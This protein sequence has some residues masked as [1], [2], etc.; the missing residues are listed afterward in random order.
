MLLVQPTGQCESLKMMNEQRL[1]TLTLFL[2]LYISVGLRVFRHCDFPL[3][4]GKTYYFQN[5]GER[6]AFVEYHNHLITDLFTMLP[7]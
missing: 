1:Q 6:L 3:S 4:D 5:L 7:D 2:L